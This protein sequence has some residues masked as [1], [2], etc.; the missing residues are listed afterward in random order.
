MYFNNRKIPPCPGDPR[1]YNLVK[2]REGYYWRRKRGSV[3][4]ATV[5]DS[6]NVNAN[7]TAA[8]SPAASRIQRALTPFFQG[9]KRGRLINRMSRELR[10]SLKANGS[11]ELKYLK[12]IDCQREHPFEEMVRVP[13]TVVVDKKTARIEIPIEKEGIRHLSPIVTDYYFE[14]ILLYGDAG[15][16]N[17]LRTESVDSP[18]YPVGTELKEKCILEFDLP[19]SRNWIMIL[20]INSLEGNELAIHPRHYRMKFI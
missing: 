2:T 8:L 12:G 7:A 16:E 19:R 3:K 1:D 11:F 9:I 5:N 4:P 15:K 6:F 10:K 20:K 14:A 17:G 13:Y 18:L